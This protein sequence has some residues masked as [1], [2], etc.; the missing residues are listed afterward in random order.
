M[1]MKL[2]REGNEIDFDLNL[3][4]RSQNQRL[5]IKTLRA[6]IFGSQSTSSSAWSTDKMALI[7]PD[8]LFSSA[9]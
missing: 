4:N 6:H 2:K 1:E 7:N 3:V 5:E 9:R 8:H